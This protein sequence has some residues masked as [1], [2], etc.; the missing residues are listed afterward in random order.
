MLP[1]GMRD[2]FIF[3]IPTE[4]DIHMGNFEEKYPS[5]ELDLLMK[6]F[7][8]GFEVSKMPP[9]HKNWNFSWRV[10]AVWRPRCIPEGYRLV[11][12]LI[13]GWI[14][15]NK[16]TGTSTTVLS[17][18]QPRLPLWPRTVFEFLITHI[19]CEKMII[20][21]KWIKYGKEW[22]VSRYERAYEKSKTSEL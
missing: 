18:G 11:H 2:D 8:L 13:E 12:L 7:D 4:K 5:L 19:T 20:L 15:A 1:G 17:L 14:H 21:R 22:K 9:P 3:E 6:I 10:L 16:Y